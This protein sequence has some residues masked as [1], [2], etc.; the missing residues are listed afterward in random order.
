[1][2]SSIFRAGWALPALALLACGGDPDLSS[3]SNK[4]EV[5]NFDARV[6]IESTPAPFRL[7]CPYPNAANLGANQGQTVPSN[8]SWM[9]YAAQSNVE[10]Q[11][12][13]TDLFDCDG[14][15]GY[16]ALLFDTS[17]WG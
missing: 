13:I 10:S 3:D 17:R 5:I 2:T 14:S 16:H 7:S 11:V 4:N 15:K 9:G 8:L 6:A 1:M 12:R